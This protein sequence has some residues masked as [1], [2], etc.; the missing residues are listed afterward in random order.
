MSTDEEKLLAILSQP[1]SDKSLDHAVAE[2]VDEEFGKLNE[3]QR[4]LLTAIMRSEMPS[5]EEIA[6]DARM[7]AHNAEIQK[8]RDEKQARKRL[9]RE[10]NNPRRRSR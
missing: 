5:P 4:A 10:Q 1:D 6:R 7:A 9:R 8:K 3:K 2:G